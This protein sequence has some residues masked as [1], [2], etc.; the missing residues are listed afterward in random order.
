ML[1]FE[2]RT[3]SPSARVPTWCT[4]SSSITTWECSII[5]MCFFT[6]AKIKILAKPLFHGTAAQFVN[7]G[8]ACSHT[9]AQA[10]IQG[11]L[12]R[13]LQ[14]PCPTQ[15]IVARV[16]PSCLH[17]ADL[18]GVGRNPQF[19]ALLLFAEIGHDQ[20]LA[21]FM[22]TQKR[23]KGLVVE[24][25]IILI[26]P[27]QIVE[28]ALDKGGVF[29]QHFEQALVC[30][31]KP[32]GRFAESFLAPMALLPELQ[33]L[34]MPV[35]EDAGATV[36]SAEAFFVHSRLPQFLTK[37]KQERI[38]EHGGRYNHSRKGTGAVAQKE[39]RSQTLLIVVLKK[40]KQE[41]M[42]SVGLLPGGSQRRSRSLSFQHGP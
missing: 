39:I 19:K 28:T 35:I 27:H 12:S 21:P 25:R 18:H 37:I 14:L 26:G 34:R 33:R 22:V 42:Q 38:I 7:C 16:K 11:D 9:C 1:L 41:T 13:E 5:R 4:T 10:P 8:R 23:K 32:S 40:I 30:S 20:I 31:A 6:S 3:G 36:H 15:Q 29:L 24:C 17:A 2:K